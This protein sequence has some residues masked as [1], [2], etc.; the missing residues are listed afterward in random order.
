M[1]SSWLYEQRAPSFDN[2]A[3]SQFLWNFMIGTRNGQNEEKTIKMP[4]KVL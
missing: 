4:E 2:D 3:T 1:A